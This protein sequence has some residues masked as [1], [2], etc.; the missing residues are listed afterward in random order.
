MRR[1]NRYTRSDDA[2]ADAQ[3]VVTTTISPEAVW[4]F[5]ETPANWVELIPGYVSHDAVGDSRT[6]W[7][8]QVDLG[9]FTRLVEAEATVTEVIPLECVRFT[10]QGSDATPFKGGGEVRAA[11]ADGATTIHIEVTMS[12][13]GPLGPVVNA[14]ASPVLPRVITAFADALTEKLERTQSSR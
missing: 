9:P 6:V 3:Y 2:V 4:A 10:L 14:V 8:V 1:G 12:P 11:T 7:K 13:Q 5:C